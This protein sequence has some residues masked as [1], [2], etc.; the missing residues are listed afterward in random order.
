MKRHQNYG[1]LN[2]QTAD[3]L[4]NASFLFFFANAQF[5]NS[6]FNAKAQIQPT[7]KMKECFRQ[8]FDNSMENFSSLFIYF[9]K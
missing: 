6:I 1:Q 3:R 5:F 9:A 4:A 8:R 2:H 7:K